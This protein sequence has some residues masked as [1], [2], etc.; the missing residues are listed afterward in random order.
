MHSVDFGKELKC[1]SCG[2]KFPHPLCDTYEYKGADRFFTYFPHTEV[3]YCTKCNKIVCIQK[4]IKYS[5][6]IKELKNATK[7]RKK[8]FQ[9][10]VDLLQGKDSVDACCDCGSVNVVRLS[11]YVCPNCNNG[12]LK[13]VKEKE[14]SGIRFHFGREYILPTLREEKD[15]VVTTANQ[16]NL[17]MSILKWIGVLPISIIAWF[18]TYWIINLLYNVFNPV[19]MTKWAISIMSSGG[20]GM[21]FVLAGVW[22]APK[23]KKITSVV[24]AT[25]M[26]IFALASMAFAFL[27]YEGNGLAVSVVSTI[28]TIV[29]CILACVQTHES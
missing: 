6:A 17:L 4:G 27:G 19:E 11:N 14:D 2:V 9:S 5:D 12:I 22:I 23:G 25:I 24:L 7:E 26:S 10:L 20:S 29:G 3:G 13:A 18:V 1:T 15:K 21:A 8:Y 28:S 16:S